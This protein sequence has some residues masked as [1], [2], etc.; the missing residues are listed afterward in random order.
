MKKVGK[1]L[2][3]NRSSM[4]NDQSM[5]MDDSDKRKLSRSSKKN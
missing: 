4:Q 2:S 1:G 5:T 3:T